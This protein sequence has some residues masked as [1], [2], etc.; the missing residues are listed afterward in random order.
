MGFDI[1]RHEKLF[2]GGM[3]TL[4]SIVYVGLGGR[5]L[6]NYQNSDIIF[7][8]N[9]ILGLSGVWKTPINFVTF[10]QIGYGVNYFYPWLTLYPAYV[11]IRL[12]HSLTIGIGVFIIGVNILTGLIAYYSTKPLLND[13]LMAM[14]FSLLYLFTTYRSLDLYRRFDIAEFIA[15]A[16]IPLMISAL[17]QIIIMGKSRWRMLAIT[18][19][20]ILY[21]H[22]LSVI[23][24]GFAGV[25]M[26]IM[27][28]PF[29]K[30]KIGGIIQIT[31]ALLLWVFLSVGFLIPFLWQRTIGVDMPFKAWLPN[32]AL[33]VGQL[34]TGGFSNSLG[35]NTMTTASLGVLCTLILIGGLFVLRK[36]RIEWIFL[37]TG[38]LLT[39]MMTKLFPWKFLGHSFDFIQ[40]PWRFGEVA[41]IFLL[42]F[43][44]SWLLK[45]RHSWLVASFLV[46]TSVFSFGIRTYQ[47][48]SCA[49]PAM[50]ITYSDKIYSP[51]P[52]DYQPHK[53]VLNI[54]GIVQHRFTGTDARP[55]VK[56][57][58][59]YISIIPTVN[60]KK[61]NT[62]FEAYKGIVT[63]ENNGK[64]LVTIESERG[65]IL[66]KNVKR[67][68]PIRITSCW[69]L[70]MR[71]AQLISVIT[72]IGITVYYVC[73]NRHLIKN[74]YFCKK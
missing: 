52:F 30:N 67:G 48:R 33:T 2:V 26:T 74:Y 43:G 57:K 11:L 13:R 62:P 64:K 53:A 73:S 25:V 51:P 60:A 4:F 47:L 50:A 14:T 38:I 3:V 54:E 49:K 66:I 40:F 15:M 58:P 12:T 1:C 5:C 59:S 45:W 27:L 65:T 36:T 34:I 39:L 21:T 16:F 19:A 44:V 46:I 31:K 68:E 29:S 24:C 17:Y 69:P 41:V 22:V 56:I 42:L 9:R 18:M 71:I 61:L 55:I 23:V 7:H 72:L 10:G 28:Y 8:L 63:K 32:M 70:F 35:S 37:I 6:V 20:L